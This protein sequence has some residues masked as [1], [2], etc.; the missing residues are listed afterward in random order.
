MEERASYLDDYL[1]LLQR[2]TL[3]YGIRHVS[4]GLRHHTRAQYRA[5]HGARVADW[6]QG[7]RLSRVDLYLGFRIQGSRGLR[8]LGS[9][10]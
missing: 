5:S 6:L 9:R 8:G 7:L 4:T 3:R 10:V 1:V 2:D